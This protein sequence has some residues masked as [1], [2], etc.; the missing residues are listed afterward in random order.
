MYPRVGKHLE[1]QFEYAVMVNENSQTE[2]KE[3]EPSKKEYKKVTAST[4]QKKHEDQTTY[5]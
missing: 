2:G 3:F 1:S 4:K 5:D